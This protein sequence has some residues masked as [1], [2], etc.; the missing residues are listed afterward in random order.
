MSV[1]VV[2]LFRM[3]LLRPSDERARDQLVTMHVSDWFRCE[4]FRFS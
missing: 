1:Q 3:G 2:S 4:W